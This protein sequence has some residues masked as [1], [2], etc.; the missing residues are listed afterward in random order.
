M[1]IKMGVTHLC[2]VTGEGGG[3]GREPLDSV[4]FLRIYHLHFSFPFSLSPLDTVYSGYA[5]SLHIQ[6]L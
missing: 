1:K 4:M 6:S 3:E 2:T 5:V